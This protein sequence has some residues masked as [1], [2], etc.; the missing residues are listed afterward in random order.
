MRAVR[1]H[2]PLDLRP[3]EDP[4]PGPPANGEALVKIEA[5]G[6]CGSDLHMYE[7]GG[8][9]G[10]TVDHPFRLGHEF[11]GTVIAAGAN[12]CTED[13]I[14]LK[15]NQRVAVE[16]AVPCG[17][18]ENC[19]E[20]NP[21]LCPHHQ[22]FGVPPDDGALCEQLLVPA[23]NCFVLPDTV[24]PEAGALLEPLG[25]ALHAVDLAKLRP[26]NSVAIFGAG[27]IGLLI[28]SVARMAGAFPLYVFDPI[29]ERRAKALELG[30]TAAWDVAPTDNTTLQPLLVA[31]AGRGVDVVVEA[32]DAGRSIDLSFTAVRPGGR[33]VLVGIPPH[34]ESQ[35][36]HANPRRKGLT[37]RFSRRMKH[38]YPRAIALYAHPM[39]KGAIDGLVTHR[40]PLSETA[41]A[42]DLVHHYR[43]GVLKAMI[44]LA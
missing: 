43:D 17:R 23:R 16:P 28:L 38:T 18:C 8:I 5:V 37:V 39:M 36:N 2:G 4:F 31:T 42:F 44:G 24:S 30:A 32:A 21:N 27:P 6:V 41:R 11:A 22:F 7:T 14:S 33:A 15:P 29:P 34:G 13:G 12:A 1:L 40:F 3:S 25:V 10:R 9:G 35:F 20:G 26:G 19:R